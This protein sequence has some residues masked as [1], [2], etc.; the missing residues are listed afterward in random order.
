M[1]ITRLDEQTLEIEQEEGFMHG[2]WDNVYRNSL[3]PMK[4]G[5]EVALSGLTVKVLSLTDD[6]RPKRVSFHFDTP[7][8]DSS[9]NFVEWRLY[10]YFPFTP[11]EIG[12]TV[13][14]PAQPLKVL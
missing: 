9:L 4:I 8:E 12:E 10:E 13:S 2:R 3:H 14:L 6:S 11:P 1:Q 7:L 5:Q